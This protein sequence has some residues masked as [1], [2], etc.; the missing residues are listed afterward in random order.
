MRA[1][2]A[3]LKTQLEKTQQGLDTVKTAAG[4]TGNALD[5]ARGGVSLFGQSFSAASTTAGSEMEK[6][7]QKVSGTNLSAE[8]N[9]VGSSIS[10]GMAAGISAANGLVAAAAR[11]VAA[12]AIAAA[13]NAIKAHSPSEE[14]ENKVGE[15][16]SAGM[17]VGITK[18]AKKPVDAA[19]STALDTLEAAEKVISSITKSVEGGV[20]AISKLKDYTA[21]NQDAV[22][23]FVNDIT[24]LVMVFQG[25]ASKFQAKGLEAATAFAEAVSKIVAP[26]ATSVAGFAAL[27]KYSA[28]DQDQVN[29][30]AFDLTNLTIIFQEAGRKFNEKGLLA[31]TTFADAAGKIVGVIANGV[32]AFESL[33][34]Y[35]GVATDAVD[36]FTSDLSLLAGDFVGVSEQFDAEG[37]KG[38]TLF[39][40]SVGK[41]VSVI[42]N[43]VKGFSDLENYKGVAAESV[44][45]FTK[46]L[47]NLVTDFVESA[48][49]FDAEGLKAAG[50]FADSAGKIVGILSNGVQGFTA[51]LT[52]KSVPQNVIESFVNDI[53]LAVNLAS[54]AAA[55]MDGDMLV[56][57]GKF[58]ESVGKIFTGFK[59]AMDLFASLKDFKSTPSTTIQQFIDEV[60][61]TVALATVMSQK[62]DTELVAQAVKFSDSVGKIFNGLKTALETFKSLE[63]YKSIPPQQIQLLIDAVILATQL[64][65][66]AEQ[67]SEQ[68]KMRADHFQE[69]LKAG[70]LAIREAASMALEAAKKAAQSVAEVDA[71]PN[72]P[73]KPE[74]G[75]SGGSKPPGMATGGMVAQGGLFMVGEKGPE[76]AMLP[77]GTQIFNNSQTQQM[78]NLSM[79][80]TN[81][82]F[83]NLKVDPGSGSTFIVEKLSLELPNVQNPLN[84][85][86]MRQAMEIVRAEIGKLGPGVASARAA[87][88][89]SR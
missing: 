9:K 53:T 48:G 22:N 4:N 61:F 41:M 88:G 36:V 38:A 25:A 44:D 18:G 50:A 82:V 33:A 64:M 13:M 78:L 30:F 55:K 15:P 76:L 58:G 39:A 57:V 71:I 46:D 68:F 21:A 35:K 79:S 60:T 23:V 27:T 51:L 7:R 24:N 42:G 54:I 5:T 11:A 40:D 20:S 80:P 29:Q 17:A 69:N 32:K 1:A 31:A 2:H 43:G 87:K 86:Q 34:E 6:I 37:L 81:Q 63:T 66:K 3:D 47:N 59:A 84:A 85:T 16:I 67:S 56:Q 73:D 26:I 19:K 74:G 12:N 8:A 72:P 52:Y 70:F 28:A 10:S 83:P 62:A 89:Q 75:K 77:T 49:W 14:A 45:L 65:A